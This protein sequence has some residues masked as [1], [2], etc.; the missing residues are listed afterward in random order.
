ME[1]NRKVVQRHMR[2]MGIQ[3][4]FPGPHLRRRHLKERVYPYLLRGLSI[5]APTRVWGIDIT[6]IRMQKGWMYLVAVLDWY[7]C[8]VLS[9]ELDMT[10]EMPFVLSAVQRALAQAVPIIWN[11]DQGSHFTSPQYCDLL[12]DANVH[13]SRDGKGRAIDNIF[14]FAAMAICEI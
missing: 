7:S 9:W 6:S 8:Y 1:V 12:R 4:I 14:D 5:D 11:S 3:A 2:E 13:I 10:L